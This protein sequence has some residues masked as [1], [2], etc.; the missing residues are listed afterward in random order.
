MYERL[1]ICY[2]SEAS[3]ALAMFDLTAV[4]FFKW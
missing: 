4:K 2:F 1:Q 3:G